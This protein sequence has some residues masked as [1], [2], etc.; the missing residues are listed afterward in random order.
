LADDSGKNLV[1]LEFY[2][3]LVRN[4]DRKKYYSIGHINA[5]FPLLLTVTLPLSLPI[6]LKQTKVPTLSTPSSPKMIMQKGLVL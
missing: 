3:L 5:N 2:N 4:I 6:L 1:K